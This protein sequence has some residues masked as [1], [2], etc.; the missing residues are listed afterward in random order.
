MWEQP[1]IPYVLSAA[2]AVL[3][4]C[5]SLLGLALR[6]EYRDV[7]WIRATWFGN[8]WVTLILAL[9]LLVVAL[10]LVRRGSI[11]GQLLWLGML[12]Y[13]TYTYAFYLFGAAL[14]V[15]FPL[16]AILLVLSVVGLILALPRLDVSAV[17]A[18]FTKRTPVR[19][20]GGCLVGIGVGL[21][22]VWLAMWAGYAFA[23]RPTP[24]EPEVFKLVAA[25]DLT[26]MVP[27]LTAGGVLLWRRAAWGF[28]LST[29]PGVQGALYLLILSVTSLILMRRDLAEP[30]G[31]L[32]IWGPLGLITASVTVLLL[33]Y[34]GTTRS[35]VNVPKSRAQPA[36]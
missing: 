24:I 33:T 7:E 20:I 22:G 25:L 4:G 13:S 35:F 2:V 3:M 30:P 10:A 5:P 8:D 15:F 21:A 27:A 14:N 36:A 31:E 17:A 9:P 16:Y 29:V 32:P 28:V 6:G 12:G 34:A 11:R 18:G 19:I 26:V 1:R 23:G